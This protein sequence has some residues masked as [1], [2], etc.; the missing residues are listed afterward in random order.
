MN[1]MKWWV[2]AAA[3]SLMVVAGVAQAAMSNKMEMGWFGGPVYTG[4][5]ALTVTAALVKA[6][7]GAANFT[8]PKALVSMLGEKTVNAEVAKLTK[9]Y[10]KKKVDEFIA[11][12]TFAVNNGLKV[13]TAQ[14]VKLPAAPGR[15]DLKGAKL[16]E[17][18][19][20]A[21]MAKDGTWW[22]GILFDKALSHPIHLT[23]MANIEGKYSRDYD[24]NIHAVLNQAMY[25]VG[26]ALKIKGVKLASTH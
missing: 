23:V 20:K 13:A 16:A 11:G 3:A 14:G 4:A 5:P 24:K 6:G 21:G 2:A 22:S 17:T 10:G 19:V 15:P 25:D 26:Q 7:G 9:Q 8:F 12:M 1:R 18:L